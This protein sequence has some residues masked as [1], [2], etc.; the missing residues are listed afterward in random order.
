MRVIFRVMVVMLLWL[1]MCSVAQGGK[2]MQA[3]GTFEVKV[4]PVEASAFEK[5]MGGA[6]YEVSKEWA[7]DFGGVSKGEML[8]SFTESTGS[9]AYVAMEQ[10]TGRLGGKSG[11][12]YLAHKAVMTKGDAASGV[13]KIE[14]VRGSGTGELA[15][16]SGELQI[17]I[18]AKGGH[19]YVLEYE[20]P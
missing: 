15:G 7:G 10:V 6:R 13:M 14:V 16:L 18:D 3:K 17:V 9:M 4:T 20:L 11:S 5:G 8:T 12:F 2:K 19:S 1:P